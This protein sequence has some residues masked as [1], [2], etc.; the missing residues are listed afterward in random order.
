MELADS[1]VAAM[2][3]ELADSAAVAME[4]ELAS[5]AA[6]AVTEEVSEEASEEA[7]EEVLEEVSG[8]AM[9]GTA[10]LAS[11]EDMAVEQEAAPPMR[12]PRL[13]SLK[14]LAALAAQEAATAAVTEAVPVWAVATAEEL[15]VATVDTMAVAGSKR[16]P[17]LFRFVAPSGVKKHT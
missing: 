3:V 12:C 13:S 8:V 15:V 16:T 2:E 1:A 11:A 9:V 5:V 4:V 17:M 6:M 10:V 14:L 7:S